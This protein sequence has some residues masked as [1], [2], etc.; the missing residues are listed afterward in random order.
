MAEAIHAL[1]QSLREDQE[2]LLSATWEVMQE[3]AASPVADDLEALGMA[4]LRAEVVRTA[5]VTSQVV[6]WLTHMNFTGTVQRKLERNRATMVAH[7]TDKYEALQ[8]M[9]DDQSRTVRK[10]AETVQQAMVVVES[11]MADYSSEDD[12]TDTVSAVAAVAATVSASARACACIRDACPHC[13]GA[14]VSV[15]RPLDDMHHMCSRLLT[16]VAPGDRMAHLCLP[17]TDH[18]S[19]CSWIP[20]RSTTGTSPQWCAVPGRRSWYC[21]GVHY[22]HLCASGALLMTFDMNVAVDEE[23]CASGDRALPREV[24]GSLVWRTL[25]ASALLYIS[26]LMTALPGLE[27]AVPAVE[28]AGEVIGCCHC[29]R[30]PAVHGR[31]GRP[32]CSSVRVKFS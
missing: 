26:L 16:Q 27:R 20:A 21:V 8:R 23:E 29:H 18:S 25:A 22:L 31:N 17:A 6:V 4:Q 12:G 30:P 19:R 28:W 5:S 24:K 32:Y 9:V 13:G 15:P 3:V 11:G 1:R 14:R 10:L 2:H 7:S